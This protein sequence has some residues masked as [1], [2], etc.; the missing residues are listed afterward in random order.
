M[1]IQ[2]VI[3]TLSSK[4]YLQESQNLRPFAAGPVQTET[5]QALL[6]SRAGPHDATHLFGNVYL[7]ST[8]VE[9]EKEKALATGNAQ[10]VLLLFVMVKLPIVSQVSDGLEHPQFFLRIRVNFRNDE[11]QVHGSW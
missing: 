8:K 2:R 4:F 1:W 6:Q 3:V 7:L 5:V 11:S 10:I 9:L